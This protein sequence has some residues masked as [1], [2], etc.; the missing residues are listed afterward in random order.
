MKERKPI[1]YD[2]QRVRWRLTR[3]IMEISGVLLTALLAYFFVSVAISVELPSGLLLDNKRGYHAVKAKP[4]KPVREGR[5]RRVANIGK[6]PA[7][8]E[9]VRAGFFV[10]WDP[11]SLATLK[12]HYK[13]L[14]LLIPEQLHAVTPDGALTVV[15]Y[16]RFQTVKASPSEAITLLKD[17][18]LHRWMKSA[19]VELPIMGLLNNYDGAVWR[20]QELA[21]LLSNADARKQL[22]RDV[23]D[24]ATQAH[25]AG[26]V[27][28]FEGVPEHS[29]PYFRKFAAELA[30][31]LHSAGLKVMF[32]LPAR[33]EAYDYK[34]FGKQ[35]DAIVLM[36]YDQHWLTSEAGPIAGQDWFVE[37][38]RQV[39]EQVPAQKLIVGIANYAYDWPEAPKKPDKKN[40]EFPKEFSVQEA[41]L[42]ASE[43]ESEIEIEFDPAS[44]NPHY[45]YY[46]E[47]DRIH[48][49]WMLDA[50]TAYNQLRAS[51]RLG[52]QG[53]ALWR[54]GSAD[55]S[56]WPAWDT[57]RPDDTVRQKLTDIP[58]GP[59]LIL[60]GEG[61]IWPFV[62]TPKRGRRRLRTIQPLTYLQARS[63][64]LIRSLSILIKSAMPR[65]KL[66]LRSTTDQTRVGRRRFSTF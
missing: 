54:L 49:V 8:Y 40:V 39:L 15:D 10:S 34:F 62:D 63:T 29:Q 66:R 38:L 6:I 5:K 3:R 31:A 14:D 47:H 12:K 44:L 65:K 19:N 27:V 45:S 52:V 20:D 50:V 41:L 58:S 30:P 56:L 4:K 18:K 60:D 43:S 64:T 21:A 55:S 53:T 13:D 23:A 28:D 42:R 25:Q 16:E 24:Y 51:E 1:F 35:C 22:V 36:N 33:D 48:Q 11:N 46:D 37:N 32:A 61:D 57:S 7:G 26:I 2:A 17:D 59:D 9:P